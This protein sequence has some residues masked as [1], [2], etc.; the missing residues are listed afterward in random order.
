[1]CRFT[2][3]AADNQPRCC[4]VPG[5]LED[6]RL[7]LHIVRHFLEL[8]F[9]EDHSFQVMLRKTQGPGVSESGEYEL[10]MMN[11]IPSPCWQGGG[12]PRGGGR[13]YGLLT[14]FRISKSESQGGATIIQT[15]S[16][17]N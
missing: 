3:C 13:P 1:M 17:L 5:E 2:H 16:P 9:L 11:C 14:H 10:R 6:A 12:R 15:R 4:A 8:Y 7:F